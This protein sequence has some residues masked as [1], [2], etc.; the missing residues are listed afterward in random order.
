LNLQA[1]APQNIIEYATSAIQFQAQ[2]QN[3]EIEIQLSDKLPQVQADA[4]KS[5]W[6]LVNLLTNA[7]RY[8]PE[9]VKLLFRRFVKME[10]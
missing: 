2:Q 1:V 5:A 3:I 7:I 4:E 6:I 9:T 10:Q 8:S